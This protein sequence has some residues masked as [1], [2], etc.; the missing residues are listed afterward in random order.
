[1]I[2]CLVLLFVIPISRAQIPVQVNKSYSNLRIKKIPVS[3]DTLRFDSLSVIPKTFIIQ[4]VADSA[5][6]LNLIDA[7]LVWKIRPV[8]DSIFITYRV[9]PYKL[10]AVT[11]RLNFDSIGYKFYA[12]PFSFGKNEEPNSNNLFDFGN[13]QHNGS[14]G[15]AISFGNSQ[16]AVVNSNFNLTLNGMLGDSIE[17]NAAIT[18]NNLPLQPDG[19]TQ[20]LNEFDQVF[21]QFKKR[22]WQLSLGDIDIRQKQN[23]FL[24][25]YK[26][27]QGLSFETR[28]SLSRNS[29]STTLVSGSIAKGKFT[30]N[31]FQGLE[32]NQGPYHLTGANNELFFVILAGTERIFIDG[33]LLQRGEDQDY[34]INYN[35]AEL[36]FTPRR[37]ITKDSRIQVEFEYADRNYLNANLYVTQGFEFNKKLKVYLAAFN[38]NDAKNSQI[39]QELDQKQIAFLG[40]IGDSVQKAFYPSAVKDSSFDASKILYEKNYYSTGTGI[41][42]FY[43]YSTNTSIARYDLAFSDLGPG[44]G[45]Y[46]PDF[47]G[48][49][50]KV[51]K[52]LMPVAGVKQ[53]NYEPVIKLIAPKKQQLVS[54]GADYNINDGTSIKSE[55]AMSNY[56]VNT[57]SGKDHGDDIGLAAKILFGNSRLLKS[58]GSK[59][60]QLISNI[61]YEYVNKKFKPLERLRYVEF[62]RDWGLGSQ[63]QPATEN[64]IRASAK[65]QDINNNT[66]SYELMN[67]NRSDNYNGFQQNLLQISKWKGWQFNNQLSFTGFNDILTKGNFFKPVIDLSKEFKKLND[68]RIGFR[69]AVEKNKTEDKSADTLT[70]QSFS[71]ETYSAYL[72]SSESKKNRYGI[73]FFTRSDKYPSGTNFIRGD[74]SMNVNLQSELLANKKHQLFFNATFR[75]LKVLDSV[76]RQKADETILGRV[77]YLINEWKGLVNGNVL[78][79]LGTGQEQKRDFVYLEVPAGT[80]QFAWI[81]YNGDGIQQLNEFEE[82]LFTDQKKYIRIFTPTI[83]FVKA[84]YITFNYSMRIN[85]RALLNN[86]NMNGFKKIISRTNFQS[87]MQVNKKSIAEGKTEFNPFKYNLSDTA[88]ITSASV[89]LNTF[90]FNRFSGKWGFDISNLRN[91]GKVLL[92]Y[93]YESRKLNDWNLKFRWNISG[94]IT[95]DMSA[96]KG[97]SGLYTPSFKNRN[98][99]LDIRSVEPKLVF[100]QG[101]KFRLA[102]GYKLDNK[103]NSPLYGEEKST[104]N[105]VN[106]ETK[107]NVLQNSS[108]TARFTFNNIDYKYPANTTV[109]YIML[110]GLLPGSNY[111]WNID[112]TKRL[113][114]ALELNFQYEGRKPGSSRTVH[115]GR[116][117]IR[118]LL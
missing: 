90:S 37:M 48:A 75:K 60:L 87:S 61:D 42:S 52:F 2:C 69:Y 113:L 19:T 36:T 94:S 112:F 100:I 85:P 18:D 3:A 28:N 38:N 95:L 1:M 4:D 13:L 111:L 21:L 53:G 73:N 91:R 32:G 66:F 65:L 76:S 82:A 102:A 25:F 56:D 40:E 117:S 104:S 14:F 108:V 116:A 83:Q 62:S 30:R 89:L 50:G 22:N 55:I 51:F 58:S 68:Y 109:G 43:V 33:Q 77:E 23:Y 118:A 63:T 64:I 27:L 98:Y 105:S 15:R 92:T 7:F 39:N 107:Y 47:N 67:Y 106:V 99:E 80:G 16:D 5:Y 79:E 81:D 93:G 103:K 24:N 29:S 86:N 78:Y 35:T 49:N 10:N 71:F 26:R 31:I 115:I 57:F 45:N 41:D 96:K 110:D 72:K 8:K 11:Q 9:F 74:R 59:K 12:K 70:A 34:V 54:L 114:N 17:I 6:S 97:L 44:K 84:N 88:L 20:Q 46:I 101:T